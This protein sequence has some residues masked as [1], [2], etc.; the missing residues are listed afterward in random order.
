MLANKRRHLDSTE[1]LTRE[2]LE[3][4]ISDLKKVLSVINKQMRRVGGHDAEMERRVRRAE[5]SL[6]LAEDA[7]RAVE[8]EGA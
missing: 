1:G 6:R 4:R 7:F 5:N 2:Q 3:I 8:G